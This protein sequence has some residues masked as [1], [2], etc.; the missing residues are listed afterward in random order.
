[1]DAKECLKMPKTRPARVRRSVALPRTL[2]E[3]AGRWAPRELR[4]N[5]NRLVVVSLEEYVARRKAL[6][7]EEA[8]ARMA[9][10]PAL[11]R[12][13]AGIAAEFEPAALDGLR[14]ED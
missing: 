10:D 4:D 1:M 5:L 9:G 2:V 11:R 3:E 8:M 7:F 13:C 6:A 12:Q 14:H